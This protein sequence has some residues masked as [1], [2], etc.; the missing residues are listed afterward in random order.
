MGEVDRTSEVV[1]VIGTGEMGAAVGRRMRETG[2]RVL[3][4]L[5][6]RTGR[7]AERVRVAGLEV[8]DSDDALVRDAGFALSIVPPGVAVEVAQG[9]A[10]A[11]LR[12]HSKVIFVEC[13]A[14]APATTARIAAIFAGIGCRFI[15][16]GIIGGPPLPGTQDPAKG[17]RFYVSGPDAHLMSQLARY[18]LDIAVLDG[19]VGAASGLKLAYACITKGLTALGAAMIAAAAR[20]G[21][22]GPLREE[23]ARTQAQMLA[24]IDRFMP[25]MFPKAYRWVAEMEQI[26]EF[27]GDEDAGS[28]IYRGAARLFEQIAAELDAGVINGRITAITEFCKPTKS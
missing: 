26:A 22:A 9:I 16:A 25:T 5:T 6:G 13:N 28:A 4:S 7:S 19:P 8:V 18:G 21:L 20:D 2:A 3:T 24:R 23:L 12:T 10:A 27:L 1:A 15:D 11:I 17:P 14:I